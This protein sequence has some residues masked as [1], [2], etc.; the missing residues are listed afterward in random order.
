MRCSDTG[1]VDTGYATNFPRVSVFDPPR[2]D[3]SVGVAEPPPGR[4]RMVDERPMAPLAL[5]RSLS[6]ANITVGSSMFGGPLGV[7]A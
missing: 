5:F 2:I 1:M 4:D 3:P 7:G 6:L